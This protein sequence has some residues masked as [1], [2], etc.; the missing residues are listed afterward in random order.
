MNMAASIV[1][2]EGLS[3]FALAVRTSIRT[4][5]KGTALVDSLDRLRNCIS[6]IEGI[7]LRHEMEPRVH[8]I[9]NRMSFVLAR[10]EADRETVKQIVRQIYWLLGQSQLAAHSR[11]EDESIVVFTSYAEP[12]KSGRWG[13][14]PEPQN[15]L[16][17]HTIVG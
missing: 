12:K 8:S 6:A 7:L 11:R 15:Y 1:I 9:A 2:P 16:I 4:Y 3:E 17:K 10:G 13:E 5:S 14:R